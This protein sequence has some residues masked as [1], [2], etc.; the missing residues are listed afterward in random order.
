M[1]F[2]LGMLLLYLKVVFVKRVCLYFGRDCNWEENFVEGCVLF[3]MVGNVLVVW[4]SMN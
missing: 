3:E 1:L 2:V 4:F